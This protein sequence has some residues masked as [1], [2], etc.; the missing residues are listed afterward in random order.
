MGRLSWAREA[1]EELKKAPFFV[2]GLARKKVEERVA[3]QG[4]DTV[5]LADVQEAQARFREVMGGRGEKEAAALLPQENQPGAPMVVVESCR[6]QL[7]QCPN[8]LL[9]TGPWREAMEEWLAAADINERLR[10]RVSGDRVLFHHKLKIALAGCPNGC[11][12]PQIADLA[13]V[14]SVRPVF[15][16]GECTACGSCAQGCPDGAIQVREVALRDPKRC[17]GCLHCSTVCAEEAV[18]PGRPFARLY[19]GGKLGRHPRLALPAGQ[20]AS[21]GQAVQV[22]SQA[23]ERFLKEA[24]PELRFAAWWPPRP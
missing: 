6:A 12:R 18:S 19:L 14:G 15:D 5:S 3:A 16:S 8:T 4:R 10:K 11:S 24:P 17:L 7:A 2:R 13:V 20:A 23:M 21:P 22:F 1:E 9:D